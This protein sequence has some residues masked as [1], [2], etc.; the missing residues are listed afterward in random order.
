MMITTNAA[1]PVTIP[2][3]EEER[4]G[5]YLWGGPGTIRMTYVKYFNP[6]FDEQSILGCYEPD[7]LAK[8]KDLFGIT[9]CWVS[10]SWGFSD[11]TEREDRQFILNRLENFKRLGLRVHAYI[12]GPNLVYD[13]FKDKPGWWARDEKGRLITYY[14]GRKVCSIHNEEY[15][16]Y[17]VKKIEDLYGAGFDGIYVDNIQHGQLGAP[18][19]PGQ[20][21]YVFCGDASEAGR[22]AFRA[23]TGL[24]IPEDFDL[25]PELTRA[26]L[27]FRIRANTAFIA[28]LGETAHRGGMEF[29]TNFYDP[30]FDPSYIYGVDLVDTAKVQ[31]YVLFENHAMPRDDGRRHN[32]Y[33]DALIDKHYPDKRVFVVTYD[34]GVGM[35]PQFTQGQLDNLF[36]EAKQSKFSLCLKGGEFT[37][38]GKWHCLYLD[39][40]QKPNDTKML[41]RPAIKDRADLL[42]TL[43]A[44]EFIRLMVKRY[45]N[46]LVR[47]AFE[48]RL[49]RFLI[50]LGYDT[51]VK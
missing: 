24:H 22:R 10:Y 35:A 20:M 51:I 5:F 16:A 2:S 25:N 49:M 42:Q 39:Q 23:E 27:E 30:K 18:T 1:Q 11:E 13:D 50:K 14:R 7:Y 33:I 19:R 26:Y 43:L 48:W 38:N 12:Q 3:L 6:R 45:Y 8:A 32:A 34:Q 17:V 28:T 29:G 41:P 44:V 47:I 4:I 9:D 40:I 21:P 37:T 15:V 36:S 46:P 31:D